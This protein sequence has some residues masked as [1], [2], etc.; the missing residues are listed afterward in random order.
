MSYQ[1]AGEKSKSSTF[2]VQ[3]WKSSPNCFCSVEL[4]QCIFWRGD[5]ED[6]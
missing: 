1:R 2:I 5:L 3:L 4:L 6:K